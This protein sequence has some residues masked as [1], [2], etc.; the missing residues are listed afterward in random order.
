MPHTAFASRLHFWAA[1]AAVALTASCGKPETDVVEGYD[2][3]DSLPSLYTRDVVSLIS[4]SGITR[5]RIETPVWYMYDNAD[6]PYWYFPEGIKV[7]RFDTLFRTEALVLSD[8]ATYYEER[9]LWQLDRNV[10]IENIEGRIF[11]TQQLFWDQNRRIIYS[12]SA[13]RIT[14]DEEIIEGTGFLSNEQMTKYTIQRTSGIFT[15]ERD[16]AAT[17]TT[18]SLAADSL[19]RATQ[20]AD[21]TMQPLNP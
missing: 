1:L 21:T 9:Q 5:Y 4:D 6:E 12:D 18:D 8:T 17:D 11:D 13:I 7:E 16:T 19:S 3:I 15:V 14:T 2:N 10:H 20:P